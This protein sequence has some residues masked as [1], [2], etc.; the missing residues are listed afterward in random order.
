ME[1][2][3]PLVALTWLY[4]I[5]KQ[6]KTEAYLNGEFPLQVQPNTSQIQYNNV[7]TTNKK[8]IQIHTPPQQEYH[9]SN[10]G[11]KQHFVKQDISNKNSFV[12]SLSG[13]TIAAS[14]FTHNNQQPFFGSSVKQSSS[15]YGRSENVLDSMN[16][17]GTYQKRKQEIAPLFAPSKNMKWNSGTPNSS[18]LMQSRM[19]VS[20]KKTL[21]N[22]DSQQV[23]PGLVKGHDNENGELGYNSALIGRDQWMPKTIDELSVNTKETYQGRV[24]P[25][26]SNVTNRGSL[27]EIEK[28]RPDTYYINTPERYFTTTGVEHAPKARSKEVLKAENRIFTTSEKYGVP[29]YFNKPYSKGK[30]EQSQRPELDPPVKH[31]SNVFA[32]Y[33][34]RSNHTD[35]QD[36]RK[37]QISNNRTTNAYD[38]LNYGTVS[39]IF[40]AVI[41]PV[42][43]VLRPSRKYNVVGNSRGPGNAATSVPVGTVFNPADRTKTTIREMTEHGTGHQ[44]IGNQAYLQNQVESGYKTQE[45]I[46]VE[47]QRDTTT[48][49]YV[50]NMGNTNCTSNPIIYDTAYNAN[51]IDKSDISM[52]RDPTN[53]SVKLYTAPEQMNVTINKDDQVHQEF[54]GGNP[55]MSNIHTPNKANFGEMSVKSAQMDQQNDRHNPELLNSFR[56]NPYTQSL[57]TF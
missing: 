49:D 38:S 7:T 17:T 26:K 52:G 6:N 13:Q 57:H 11:V 44:F 33:Q 41:S 45:M 9:E 51:L 34:D 19:N 28:N 24:L 2:V 5:S 29:K 10:P 43:D 23:V 3:I 54:I 30:Y 18:D 4:K 50:G 1:A 31:A 16:G 35:V 47:Q 21:S 27:G 25:G 12:S 39:N 37:S 36:Y 46:P 42:I 32:N 20:N 8:G 53:S 22:F 56:Q 55:G 48:K 15:V 14:N 40:K